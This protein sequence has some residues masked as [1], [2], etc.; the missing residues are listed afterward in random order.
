MA[1]WRPWLRRPWPTQD[2]RRF[3]W[4]NH[5]RG[6]AVRLVHRH[7][8]LLPAT[9]ADDRRLQRCSRRIRRDG[10]VGSRGDAAEAVRYPTRFS[11]GSTTNSLFNSRPRVSTCAVRAP[12]DTGPI[13]GETREERAAQC[14]TASEIGADVILYGI[15]RSK[16]SGHE[17][18]PEFFL[19]DRTLQGAE[20]LV[21]QYELGEG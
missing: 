1:T 4:A 6:D 17:F 7:L 16:G 20:E 10:R 5:G 14:R 2:P 18:R 9:A 12:E 21:G 11:G 15:L 8:R 13:Q 19:T 3:A